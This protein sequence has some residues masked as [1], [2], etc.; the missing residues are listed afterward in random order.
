[1]LQA[2]PAAS[3]A[4]KAAAVLANLCYQGTEHWD[5]IRDQGGVAALVA[6]AAGQVCFSLPLSRF[7]LVAKPDE[8]P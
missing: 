4:Q 8:E 3:I 2:R 7:W 6:H 1:V 5:A